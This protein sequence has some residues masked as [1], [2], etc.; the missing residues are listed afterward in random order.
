[1]NDSVEIGERVRGRRP[2]ESGVW[3]VPRH[4]THDWQGLLQTYGFSREAERVS[5]YDYKTNDNDKKGFLS[6]SE[7]SPLCKKQ[8]RT[9][10]VVRS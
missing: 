6:S 7:H 4:G 10:E 9:I 3:E 2:K 8:T 1:M 5:I